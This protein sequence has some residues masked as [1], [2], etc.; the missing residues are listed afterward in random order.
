MNSTKTK[1]LKNE[2]DKKKTSNI[3]FDKTKQP[4]KLNST[5]KKNNIKNCIRQKKETSNIEF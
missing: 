2:F 4:R 3:D 1:T 5:Q